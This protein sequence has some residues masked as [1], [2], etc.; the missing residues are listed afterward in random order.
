MKSRFVKV[1]TMPQV[2]IF[3]GVTNVQAVCTSCYVNALI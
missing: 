2:I 3:H 1:T